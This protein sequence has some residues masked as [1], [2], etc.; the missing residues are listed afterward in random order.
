MNKLTLADIA[1]LEKRLVF[2]M[3]EDVRQQYLQSN[4]LLGPTDC[5]LLYP[6]NSGAPYDILY[7]NALKSEEWFPAPLRDVVLLGDDGCGNLVGWHKTQQVAVLWNPADGVWI[8]EQRSSVS[9]MWQLIR[10]LYEN[11][12]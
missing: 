4:G 7:M 2:S 6:Y 9:E 12:R 1:D 8:Q 5:R 3:P 10:D 11:E